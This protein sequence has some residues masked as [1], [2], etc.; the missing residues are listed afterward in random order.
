MTF[1]RLINALKHEARTRPLKVGVLALLFLVAMYFWIPL[2]SQL[3]GLSGSGSTQPRNDKPATPLALATVPSTPA[4]EA[5]SPEVNWQ[6]LHAAR[7]ADPLSHPAEDRVW[8][9]NPFAPYAE[10]RPTEEN[11]VDATPQ[12]VPTA[13]QLGLQLAG[14]IISP[15]QRLAMINGRNYR[16]GDEIELATGKT[17]SVQEIHHRHVVVQYQN[18]QVELVIPKPFERH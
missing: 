5:T 6:K 17:A 11:T 3:L 4:A 1:P 2:A 8:D 7:V 9:K 10:V 18:Y 13:E 14:V 16:P 12:L 15:R